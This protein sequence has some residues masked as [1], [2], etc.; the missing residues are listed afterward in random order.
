MPDDR[1]TDAPATPTGYLT[2][3]NGAGTEN[4]GSEHGTASSGDWMSF[5][6]KTAFFIVFVG[7]G[8]FFGAMMVGHS[9]VEPQGNRAAWALAGSLVTLVMAGLTRGYIADV[10]RSF[11]AL[12]VG[13]AA[14]VRRSVSRGA[15]A[16]FLGVLA[17]GILIAYL[18]R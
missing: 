8:T 17:V 2:E 14:V 1:R 9:L 6:F 15:W 16:W 11:P 3:P 12:P 5:W 4:A 18:E 7:V 10:R 13:K